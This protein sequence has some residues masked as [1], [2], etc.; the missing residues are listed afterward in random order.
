MMRTFRHIGLILVMMFS[1]IT[2]TT[3]V[4]AANQAD[5]SVPVSIKLE[6]NLPDTPENF[7]VMLIAENSVYPMP[8][9]A[10]DGT[11]TLTFTG[12][13]SDCFPISYNKTGVYTYTITQ[14]VGSNSKC[15]YDL[16]EYTLT[17]Y[18]TNAEDDSG[19]EVTAVLHPNIESAKLG[20]AEFI[21]IYPTLETATESPSSMPSDVPKTGDDRNVEI[22][23][24]LFV[25]SVIGMVASVMQM[26]RHMTK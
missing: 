17:V 20:G 11:A 23:L 6:G 14:E 24:G 4:L 26:R 7:R 15:K 2:I 1:M 8:E 19:L 3:P 22:W 25:L 10:V 21:N 12:A 9:G 5:I 18:V 16:S 13:G